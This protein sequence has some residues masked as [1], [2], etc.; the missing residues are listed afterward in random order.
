[1]LHELR[2]EQH[3]NLRPLF[4]DFGLRLHGLV[5]AMFSGEFGRAWAD[6]PG[7][8]TVA[9]AEIDFWLV[10][11]NPLPPAAD[12]ALHFVPK[13]TIVT[14]GSQAWDALVR[15][16]LVDCVSER[17]RTG[18][19]TP[20]PNVWNRKRLREQSSALAAG[21]EIRAIDAD[22]IDSFLV[23]AKDFASNWRSVDAFLAHGFGFGVFEGE[24]CVAGCSSY[25]LAGGK[26]EIEIDTDPEY[27]RRGL[28]RAVAATLIEHC[29]DR[30]LEPCWDAHNPESAALALQLGFVDPYPYTVFVVR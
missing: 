16:T 1:M 18:F 2:P 8:P 29:L 22:N 25:T 13:G 15:T 21:F 30:G 23:V 11:G 4:A 14:D 5:E 10:A 3:E 24:R 28:A 17:T 6:D 20:Q 27:R 7:A 9:L 12:D 19:A 26:L